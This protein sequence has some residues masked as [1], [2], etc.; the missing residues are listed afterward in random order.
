MLYGWEAGVVVG[1]AAPIMHIV[2]HRPPIRVAYNASVF[3]IAAVV[4]GAAIAPL[5]GDEAAHVFGQVLVAALGHFGVNLLLI[6]L[7]DQR[8]RPEAVPARSCAPASRSRSS[9]SR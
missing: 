4:A 6:S 5:R 1:F 8:Q 9:R 3:S 2:E 7:V